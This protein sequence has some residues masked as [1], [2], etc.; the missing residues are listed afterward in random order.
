[1]SARAVP[2]PFRW[3][4]DRWR[5]LALAPTVIAVVGLTAAPAG[6]TFPGADGKVAFVRNN[7]T[8]TA[9]F[10]PAGYSERRL[11]TDHHTSNPR[12]SPDGQR[13]AFNRNDDIG[14]MS[15][16]GT[17]VKMLRVGHAHQPAWSPALA[18]GQKIAFVQVPPGKPGD[19]W[20]V[21][22][23]G[24]KATRLTTDGAANCGDARPSWSPAGNKIAYLRYVDNSHGG[25]DAHV[26]VLNLA[27]GASAVVPQWVPYGA[28]VYLVEGRPD[29]T[30]DGTAVE[31]LASGTC[32]EDV[33]D[34]VLKTG[35]MRLRDTN[36]SC[37]GDPEEREAGPTP[38]GGLFRMIT[39]LLDRPE[40]PTGACLIV[41][42]GQ[43]CRTNTNSY[44]PWSLVDVQPRP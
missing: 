27:T 31:F 1:M 23:S 8:W 38:S 40:G 44:S 5:A 32:A 9:S 39:F 21:P 26:V 30:P 20:T 17:N 11:T 42:A 15:A 28:E 10:S 16:T 29:F 25:C 12:W 33:V 4:R 24:G 22:A 19:I 13:I 18:K 41:P 37:E 2:G 43:K 35:E 7:D 34:Y 14:V 3:L 6:A 36:T